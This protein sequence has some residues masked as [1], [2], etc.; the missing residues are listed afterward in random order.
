MLNRVQSFCIAAC[1]SPFTL[2]SIAACPTNR[3]LSPH[4]RRFLSPPLHHADGCAVGVDKTVP[5]GS[6]LLTAALSGSQSN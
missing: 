5:S 6:A 2:A 3:L 4:L 1:L